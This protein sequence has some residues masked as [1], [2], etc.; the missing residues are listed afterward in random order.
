LIYFLQKAKQPLFSPNQFLSIMNKNFTNKS[1]TEEI[2]ERFDQ[3]VDRFSNLQTGQQSTIDAPLC[4]DLITDAA[5][6]VNP[7]SKQL[8]DIGCGAGNYSLKMLSKIPDLHCT[9]LDLSM[10]MLEKARERVSRETSGAVAI[11]RQDIREAVFPENHFDIILAG[12]V[13][14]HLREE[15]DWEYV[16][17]KLFRSLKKGGSLWISDLVVQD[18]MSIHKL[19]WDE[20]GRY[21]EKLGDEAYKEQVFA[22]IEKED[23]P[24]SVNFQLDLMKRTGFK[25]VEILHKNLCFAAFGGIK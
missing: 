23:S 17:D 11:I 22:Y 25:Q 19:I 12:A 9:L 6:A 7:S 24:R 21:L 14:H 13:L 16:F 2:R 1:T 20:Y 10:P 4:L 5:K 8:L 18:S 3:D 15:D